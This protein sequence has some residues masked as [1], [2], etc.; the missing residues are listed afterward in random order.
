MAHNQ[1]TAGEF[2]GQH[3]NRSYVDRKAMYYSPWCDL[4][5]YHLGR[6]LL[7]QEELAQRIP[8]AKSAISH[9]LVGRIA[10]PL[11]EKLAAIIRA[12]HLDGADADRFEEEALLANSPSKIR[13]LVTQLRRDL[14]AARAAVRQEH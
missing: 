7:T 8:C 10:P 6:S 12:F 13:D 11:G 1:N 2:A 4:L 5:S 14:K 3:A 9:Y